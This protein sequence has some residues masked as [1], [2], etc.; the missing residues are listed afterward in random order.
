ML[1]LSYSTNH[2]IQ[3]NNTVFKKCGILTLHLERSGG[4]QGSTLYKV[5]KM[6]LEQKVQGSALI[7]HDT[8]F[9]LPLQGTVLSVRLRLDPLETHSGPVRGLP[10]LLLL[11]EW[12]PHV[13]LLRLDFYTF[14]PGFLKAGDTHA[15]LKG[16]GA[17]QVNPGVCLVPA[18]HSME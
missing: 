9:P 16:E 14:T 13:D 8:L 6:F 15:S 5:S 11:R 3:Q 10:L 18:F 17:L 2:K 7:K 4:A 1:L 12:S